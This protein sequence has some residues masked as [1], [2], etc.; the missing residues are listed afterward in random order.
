MEAKHLRHNALRDKASA[1][2]GEEETP[3]PIGHR[4]VYFKEAGTRIETPVYARADL[5]LGFSSAGPA[6][7]EEYSATTVVAPG[8]EISI[9]A[10]GEIWIRCDLEG[11]HQ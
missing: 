11:S 4:R 10:L 2:K 8:D 9:G 3:A 1:R 6:I 5:P 7:I